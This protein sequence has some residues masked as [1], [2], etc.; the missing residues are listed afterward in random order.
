MRERGV[1]RGG[2]G[3]GEGEVQY[4]RGRGERGKVRTAWIVTDAS[5]SLT[6]VLL[7]R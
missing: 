3:E 4:C 6:L 7:S 5:I 2:K 1:L